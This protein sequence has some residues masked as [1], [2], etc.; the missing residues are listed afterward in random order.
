MIIGPSGSAL[1]NAA[2]MKPKSHV[3]SLTSK[4][5][6]LL[7]EALVC[8][9]TDTNYHVFFGDEH[10]DI[11]WSID[12]EKLTDYLIENNLTPNKQETLVIY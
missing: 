2:F 10:D 11:N 1:H 6:F 12:L 3:I 9:S 7:N 8:K 5:F 4:N